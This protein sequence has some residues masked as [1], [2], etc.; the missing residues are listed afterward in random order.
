M[1][2]MTVFGST[3]L[4]ESVSSVTATPSINLGE[5]VLYQGE[6]YVYCYNAGGA[7]ASVGFAVKPVTACSGYSIA[8]TFLT[9]TGAPVVGVVKHADIPAASYGWVM[10]KGWMNVHF[11][12]NS[13]VTA[14]FVM[15]GG[16]A[17]GRLGTCAYGTGGT[18]AVAGWG[19]NVN[20]A[21]G[22]TIYACIRTSF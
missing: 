12:A 11:H 13:V 18:M 16:G 7:T 4:S 15:L 9:D 8:Q 21:S 17:D 10:V 19:F 2:V 3:V 6:E 1:A 5:R 20:T 22:G 14:D